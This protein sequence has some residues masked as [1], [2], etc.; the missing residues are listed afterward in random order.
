MNLA[1]GGLEKA[2]GIPAALGEV[3]VAPDG[4][5]AYVSCPAAG[6]IEVLNLRDGK[7]EEPFRL[8]KGVD[9]LAWLPTVPK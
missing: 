9:G 8:T 2:Y 5:H 6:T 1:T 4:S 3:T 7:L